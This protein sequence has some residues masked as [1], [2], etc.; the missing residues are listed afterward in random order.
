MNDNKNRKKVRILTAGLLMLCMLTACGLGG[1]KKPASSEENQTV[2]ENTSGK[3]ADS[4]ASVSVSQISQLQPGRATDIL[5][6]VTAEDKTQQ[7]YTV[8]VFRAPIH[9]ETD[10]F[11]QGDRPEPIQP[12][13]TEPAATQQNNPSEA[14]S[15]QSLTVVIGIAALLIG[16]VI[17]YL[18]CTITKKRRH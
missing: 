12:E 17:G 18:L 11:L 5:V 7:V 14:R 1:G 3:A 16:A 6:T 4:K 15:D 2:Q 9:E 13:P 8:T 10:R